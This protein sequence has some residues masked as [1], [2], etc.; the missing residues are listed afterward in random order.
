MPLDHGHPLS[1]RA[2]LRGAGLAAAS[3]AAATLAAC[4]TPPGR[5]PEPAGPSTTTGAPVSPSSSSARVLV[6]YFSRAGENYWYGDR[7]TLKTGN[8]EVLAGM[9]SDRIDCD[10]YSIEAADPYPEAYDPTVARNSEE[11]DADARP[12]I[13]NPLPDLSAYDTVLLGSPIWNV[14]PPMIMATFVEALDLSGKD[15]RPF[16]TYAVSGLGSSAAFYSDL[17]PGARLGQ[18]LAVQ[19]EEVAES[20]TDLDQWLAAAGLA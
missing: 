5:A 4:T 10:V 14:Q 15:V 2:A 6:A 11:Q 8:T 13:A 17:A 18:G 9:I 1:R 7:R 19:G 16:V 12:E 3:I 20:A